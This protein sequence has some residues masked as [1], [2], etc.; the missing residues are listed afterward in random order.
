[1]KLSLF[2]FRGAWRPKQL[3]QNNLERG[4]LQK[5]GET[6]KFGNSRLGF[7]ESFYENYL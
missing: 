3:P 4:I 7:M 2:S 5:E 6:I 1:M